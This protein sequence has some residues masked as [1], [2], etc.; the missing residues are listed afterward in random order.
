[1]DKLQKRA[2][3]FKNLSD[4][5][6]KIVL[7]RKGKKT[8]FTIDF[9]KTDFPHLIGLHKL[10]DVLSGNI[11]TERLFDECLSGKLSYEAILKSVF[12]QKIENRFEYFDKL[13]ELLDSNNIIFKC[14]T[15]NMSSFSKIIADF[16]LKNIYENLI[17][18][19]FIEKRNCSEKQYC[20]SFIQENKIDY[21]YGQTKMTLLYKEKINKKTGNSEIQYNRL[22]CEVL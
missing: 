15:S 17:F 2:W 8:E 20:K 18:Y 21:T 19:L 22:P 9:E 4:Y 5:E 11:A 7:G 16:E 12:F 13:E 10:T 1:M 3:A 6:Y 14:N